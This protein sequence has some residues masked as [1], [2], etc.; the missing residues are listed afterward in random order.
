MYDLANGWMTWSR[1]TTATFAIGQIATTLAVQLD[2]TNLLTRADAWRAS[3]AIL[4]A[5]PQLD[6]SP[7]FNQLPQFNNGASQ[8]SV[9]LS[10]VVFSQNPA[11]PVSLNGTAA[12]PTYTGAV[13]WS[14]KI[15]GTGA[16]R[17]CGK[18]TS[19]GDANT[20]SLTTLP[21]DAFQANPILVVDTTYNFT[22]LFLQSFVGPIP[23]RWAA[24]LP[25]RSGTNNKSIVTGVSDMVI[26]YEDISGATQHCP[27][28]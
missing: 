7:N 3:T 6:Q 12:P 16:F 5:L 25:S 24:Y 27:A 11:G 1:L 22:P 15:L 9:V 21:V 19:A 26:R 14:A 13:F 2:A 20:P 4:A 18:I 10:E 8:Y 23:M 28:P 17:P